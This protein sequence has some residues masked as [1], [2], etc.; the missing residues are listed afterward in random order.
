MQFYWNR[1]EW[2]RLEHLWPI[3]HN[4]YLKQIKF[5][6]SFKINEMIVLN[7]GVNNSFITLFY[8]AFNIIVA[9]TYIVNKFEHKRELLFREK[10]LFCRLLVILNSEI[11]ANIL[12]LV[13]FLFVTST[14]SCNCRFNLFRDHLLKW[15]EN[16]Q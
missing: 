13:N 14:F 12:I 1:L 15:E 4:F 3:P 10:Q 11:M 16:Y 9:L 8:I 5:H 6:F 7:L 2:F